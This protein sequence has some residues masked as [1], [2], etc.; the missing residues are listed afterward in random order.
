MKK[1][2]AFYRHK[3]VGNIYYKTEGL[4]EK[5][6][7]ICGLFDMLYSPLKGIFQLQCRIEKQTCK[8]QNYLNASPIQF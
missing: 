2:N 1:E 3:M 6:M 5:K 4:Q 7:N 8:M